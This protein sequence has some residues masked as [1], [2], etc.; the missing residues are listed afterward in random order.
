MNLI[1]TAL[2]AAALA[3]I[4]SPVLA[5]DADNT[6][7]AFRQVC[8]DTRADYASSLAAAGQ[9]GWRNTDVMGNS[10]PNVT[11]VEKAARTKSLGDASLM[12]SLTHGTATKDPTVNVYTCTLQT[13]RGGYPMLKAAV[14]AWL[15]FDPA[16]TS[17]SVTTY[18][19]TEEG[20]K[21][22]AADASEFNTAAAGTGMQIL[23]VKRDGNDAILDYVK[24][25]K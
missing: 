19:F 3:A 13:D 7:N 10:M 12:L 23:T 5:S 14:Q 2:A 16:T 15:G 22:R 24:I 20:G 1:R 9:N 18:R 17:E 6:F 25:K 4:A 21:L 11:V 8:G